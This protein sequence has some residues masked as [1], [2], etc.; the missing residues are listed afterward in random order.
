MDGFNPAHLG[1]ISSSKK[2]VLVL[3]CPDKIQI[4]VWKCYEKVSCATQKLKSTRGHGKLL[5]S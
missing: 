4:I 3:P 5:M 1:K 2:G